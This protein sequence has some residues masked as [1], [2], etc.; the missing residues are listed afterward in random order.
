MRKF[1]EEINRSGFWMF[2]IMLACT[3]FGVTGVNAVFADA[4]PVS[5]ALGAPG[6]EGGEIGEGYIT[7]DQALSGDTKLI[8]ETIHNEVIKIAPYDYVAQNFR[9]KKKTKDHKVVV[10]SAESP[11]IKATVATAYTQSA[12]TTAAIDFGAANKLFAI[13]ETV[14]FPDIP[15]YKEDGVTL[16]GKNLVCYVVRKDSNGAPILQA[17]NGKKVSDTITIPSLAKDTRALRG[18]RVGTETQIRTEMFNVLPTPGD[19]YI[20]KN[21]IEFGTTGWFD[22][23]TKK[24]KWDDRDLMEMAIA[25]KTR[26][27]MV[28]FWLGVA[29]T[30]YFSTKHNDDTEELAYFSEG[31]W[32]Q[33]GREYDFNGAIDIEAIIDFGKYVFTGNRSSNEKYFVMGSE[34]SAEFQ[35]VIF[36]HPTL[37]GETYRDKELNISFTAVNFFGG[38]KIMFV[39]DPSLD[40]IGMSNCGFLIDHKYAFEYNYGMMSIPIDNKKMQRADSKGQAIV[41]ENSFILT[42]KNAHCRVI[43]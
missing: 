16:D 2:A 20:Q 17:R 41:E 31:I 42:N 7:L 21:I 22:N 37:L 12:V 39:D 30:G 10:Y 40:D 15:G 27:S 32:T 11:A 26:T 1:F 25:E 34:L 18:L 29:G 9:Q 38:K 28:D 13:N 35:K 4:A 24:I 23:A 5:T 43:F 3:L 14:T 36:A 6:G 19:Y 33:A 8:T